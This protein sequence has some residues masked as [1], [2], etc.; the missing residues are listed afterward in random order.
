MS[1]PQC[2]LRL[3]TAQS[4]NGYKISITLEELGLPYDMTVVDLKNMAHKDPAF[5]SINPNG[6]IPAM[7]D[8]SFGD[9]TFSLF[10]S[11]SIQQYLVDRYDS[12]HKLSYPRG[13]REYYETS[14]WLFFQNA[15]VG[16]M[17]GQANHFLR[18]SLAEEPLPYAIDRYQNETRRLYRTVDKHLETTATDFLVGG[19]MTIADIALWCWVDSASFTNI[20]VSE[21]PTLQRWHKRI[22]ARPAVQKGRK[23]PAGADLNQVIKNS[24]D[25]EKFLS[26]NREWIA[27]GL[28]DDARKG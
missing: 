27:Q 15:G 6:R 10:E 5:L 16:P 12:H 2:D 8:K 28:S 26:G 3:F 23:I 21:F 11:G 4:P 13:T 18:Y 14:N 22:S 20:D 9:A 7:K 19:K 1:T 25:F 24:A 17:Q